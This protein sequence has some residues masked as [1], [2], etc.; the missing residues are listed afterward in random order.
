MMMGNIKPAT[1][2]EVCPTLD[3]EIAIY[4]RQNWKPD[5]FFGA[6]VAWTGFARRFGVKETIERPTI[7]RMEIKPFTAEELR[8][9]RFGTFDSDTTGQFGCLKI[10]RDGSI[11]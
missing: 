9:W 7:A 2:R 4:C 1:F 6:R 10:F 11:L 3:P 8:N 5:E